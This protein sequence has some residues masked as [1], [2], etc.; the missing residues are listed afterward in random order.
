MGAN[1]GTIY[2]QNRQPFSK[3]ISHLFYLSE[4]DDKDVKTELWNIQFK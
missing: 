2:K 1:S 3:K 4:R